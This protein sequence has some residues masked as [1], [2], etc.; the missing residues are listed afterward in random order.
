MV[1]TGSTTSGFFPAIY[2]RI[3]IDFLAQFLILLTLLITWFILLTTASQRF[4]KKETICSLTIWIALILVIIFSTN[5]LIFFYTIFETS[6][7][8]ITLMVLGWGYQPERLSAANALFLYTVCASLPLLVIVFTTLSTRQSL[9]L[10]STSSILVSLQNSGLLEII[11]LSFILG[12]L[13][14]FPIFFVHIWLPKAHVE[15]PVIGSMVLAAI[16]LKLGGYGIWRFLEVC[17]RTSVLSILSIVAL[18]GGTVVRFLCI[19]QIDFKVLIAYSSVA[20][21]RFVISCLLLNTIS[22]AIAGFILIIAHGVSSSGI[23]AGANYIYI[24]LHSRNMLLVRGLIV[25]RP[26]LT[27][28]WFLICLG[29]IGAPPSINLLAEI[30]RI[31]TLASLNKIL[32][33][34]FILTSFFAVAYTLL[35]YA[36]PNQGQTRF[37]P[38]YSAQKRNL[39]FVVLGGHAYFLLVALFI[40]I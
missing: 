32:L 7:I 31:I 15:A 14:K 18:I 29:N 34:S 33:L 25:I 28:I 3:K 24:K 23:F 40:F 4:N 6:L 26:I 12:F 22:G 38:K 20:H 30:W 36:T 17:P 19:R 16:L 35:I 1:F 27:L 13:V 21:I 10:L 37:F 11:S 9:D 2:F 39:L 5:N 8:P